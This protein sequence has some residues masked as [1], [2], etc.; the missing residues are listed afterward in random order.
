MEYIESIKILN[1]TP[2][3]VELH[4]ARA[5]KVS[6][7]I[8]P[9]LSSINPIARGLVKCRIIFDEQYILSIEFQPYTLPSINSLK[10]VHSDIITYDKKFLDRTLLMSLY[11]Q[12]G[13]ADDIII[14]KNGYLSDS[15]FCNIV[16][17]LNGELFTPDT[18]LLEGVKRQYLIESDIIKTRSITAD[19]I[20]LFDGVYLINAMID[21]D[22]NIFINNINY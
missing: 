6:K 8:I 12:K 1:N 16:F 3:L 21:L 13:E 14:C 5:S 11:T 10:I 20:H 4:Q 9:D 7:I 17:S 22:D 15:Y 2:Y 18:P 19:D